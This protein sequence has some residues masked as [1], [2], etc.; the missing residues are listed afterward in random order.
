MHPP[1][2]IKRSEKDQLR[3]NTQAQNLSL[4]QFNACPF[5]VK[6]RRSFHKLN[7]PITLRDAKVSDIGNELETNGGKRKVPCLRIVENEETKWMYE[8]NDIIDYLE[9]SFA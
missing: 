9:K 8:S 2:K 4:Y 5:C 7:I 1:W 3:I 6:V